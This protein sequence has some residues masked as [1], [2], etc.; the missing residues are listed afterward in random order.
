MLWS[1]IIHTNSLHDQTEWFLIPISQS[2]NETSYNQHPAWNTNKIN[3]QL[4]NYKHTIRL[5]VQLHPVRTLQQPPALLTSQASLYGQNSLQALYIL[6]GRHSLAW[7]TNNV[8]YL[9]SW[10]I[11]RVWGLLPG[12]RVAEE[13]NNCIRHN[14][15]FLWTASTWNK[16]HSFSANAIIMPRF[17]AEEIHAATTLLEVRVDVELVSSN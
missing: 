15:G 7:L 5:P 10:T 3:M 13:F 2:S 1:C 12:F 11:H 6:H 14:Y 4:M 8:L 17:S 16:N 9:V